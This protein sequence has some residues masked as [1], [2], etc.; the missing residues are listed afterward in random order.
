MLVAWQHEV[1]SWIDVDLSSVKSCGIPE[2]KFTGHTQD[3]YPWYEFEN[4]LPKITAESPRGQRVKER[5]MYW[6]IGVTV[7]TQAAILPTAI[8]RCSQ[9]NLTL[10]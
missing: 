10:F 9:K 8:I 4:D 7:N 2:G 3:I 6:R 1:I 5:L